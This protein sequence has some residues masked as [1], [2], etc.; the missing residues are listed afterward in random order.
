[1]EM[2]RGKPSH[3]I[4][5]IGEF[6][7][8][9]YLLQ[10]CGPVK[11]GYF[12]DFVLYGVPIEV[13]TTTEHNHHRKTS[14]LGSFTFNR[15]NHTWLCEH[16]GK[17]VLVLLRDDG[18]ASV[19]IWDAREVKLPQGAD[20]YKHTKWTQFFEY[21]SGKQNFKRCTAP[22]FMNWSSLVTTAVVD[23]ERMFALEQ[24]RRGRFI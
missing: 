13:K 6:I 19:K 1:M 10:N 17:Y 5:R 4:G 12:S 18:G 2:N 11:F 23:Q 8:Y 22:I 7:A 3:T 16:G 14:G 24:Q 9:Q 21:T 20:T 15:N